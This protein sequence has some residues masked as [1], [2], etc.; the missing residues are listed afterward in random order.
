MANKPLPTAAQLREK[1]GLSRGYACDLANGN[2]KPSLKLA[3]RIEQ[4]FGVPA[5]HWLKSEAA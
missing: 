2:R 1:L 3:L 5:S 4:E